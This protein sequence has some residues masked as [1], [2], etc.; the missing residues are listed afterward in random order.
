MSPD[1]AFGEMETKR[2]SAKVESQISYFAL[3]SE[4][5]FCPWKQRLH[6]PYTNSKYFL[7]QFTF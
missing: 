3:R 6:K 2:G 4:Q 1:K 5:I 7:L